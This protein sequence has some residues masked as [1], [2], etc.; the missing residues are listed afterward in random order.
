MA[1]LRRDGGHVAM[2]TLTFANYNYAC[3]RPAADQMR[4]TA[5]GLR[6]PMGDLYSNNIQWYMIDVLFRS[7]CNFPIT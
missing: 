1:A 5:P 7:R 4:P 6:N 2:P 3:R